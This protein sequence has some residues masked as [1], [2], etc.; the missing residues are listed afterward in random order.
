M[1]NSPGALP[2]LSVD[3]LVMG[4]VAD[5]AEVLEPTSRHGHR[6]KPEETLVPVTIAILPAHNEERA[7]PT[8]VHALRTQTC[9]PIRIIVASDN[10]ADN[11]VSVA[12]SLGVEIRETVENREKK[13]GALNQVFDDLL[14]TL[15]DWDIILVQ[16]AD[17]ILDPHFIEVA[18]SYIAR[19]YGGVG[20]VFRGGAGG[21]FIGHLQRN[22]YA[23]YARDVSRLNGRC[24]VVTGTAAV[25]R[26]KTLRDVSCARLCGKLPAGNGEGAIYDTTALTED[27]ELTFALLHLGYQEGYR[28]PF[29]VSL[30]TGVSIPQ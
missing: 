13:A 6:V 8:A 23:R 25:F 24:L 1:V 14:P 9:P 22:E 3:Q 19:G 17:S 7:L 29:S 16:D 28:K 26:V 10:S 12:Q 21:G 15:E 18:T 20:G 5:K 30:L 27:N 11:T 2:Y 4:C